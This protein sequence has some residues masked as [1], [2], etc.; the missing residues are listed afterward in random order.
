MLFQN[1]SPKGHIYLK[2]EDG[3][4]VEEG[5][6]GRHPDQSDCFTIVT[7]ERHYNLAAESEEEMKDWIRALQKVISTPSP[8]EDGDG[9]VGAGKNQPLSMHAL[10]Y[11][12]IFQRNPSR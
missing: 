1:A 3:C 9:W 8:V 11:L 4:K 10:L 12:S 7:R 2:A 6:S 5:V